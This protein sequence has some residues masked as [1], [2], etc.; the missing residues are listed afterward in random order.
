MGILSSVIRN[1]CLKFFLK[2]AIQLEM[3][4]VLLSGSVPLQGTSRVEITS[5]KVTATCRVSLK[6]ASGPLKGTIVV[7]EITPGTGFGLSS[8]SA[9]DV[10]TILYFDVVE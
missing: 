6:G 7:S 9:L 5:D 1:T 8:T 2:S 10:G 4:T 3:S